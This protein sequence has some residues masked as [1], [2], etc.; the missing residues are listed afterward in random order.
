MICLVL[1]RKLRISGVIARSGER[2]TKQSPYFSVDGLGKTCP[3]LV[4]GNASQ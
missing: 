2:A 3:E 1:E 4:E